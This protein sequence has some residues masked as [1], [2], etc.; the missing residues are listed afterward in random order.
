M[1]KYLRASPVDA[2][3][4]AQAEA[5]TT[6]HAWGP[7]MYA[8]SLESGHDTVWL[9]QQQGQ[10]QGAAVLMQVLD[11]AHLQNFFIHVRHQGQGLASLLLAHVMQQAKANAASQMFLEVRCSNLRAQALYRKHGFQDYAVRKAYYRLPDGSRED[12]V[13]MKAML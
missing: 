12:A 10:L 13:L 8:S 1:D 6:P 7:V 2:E 4:I 11:E 5:E 9:C 3:R